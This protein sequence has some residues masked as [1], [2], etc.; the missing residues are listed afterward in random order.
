MLKKE[1]SNSQ[2]SE[3]SEKIS[4]PIHK[5]KKDGKK[6]QVTKQKVREKL[7]KLQ[8]EA[9]ASVEYTKDNKKS[10]KE[11]KSFIKEDKNQYKNNKKEDKKSKNNLFF[12]FL[13]ASLF[14]DT[15]PYFGNWI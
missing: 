8:E 15:R 6:K 3:N 7:A 1:K 13:L 11:S 2:K 10:K 12:L 4:A 5:R 9:L 14:H